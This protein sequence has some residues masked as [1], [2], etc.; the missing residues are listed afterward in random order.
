MSDGV[1]GGKKCKRGGLGC[2][3]LMRDQGGGAKRGFGCGGWVN[4]WAEGVDRW[5]GG[6]W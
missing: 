5:L 2:K 1:E 3:E 6:E 4:G